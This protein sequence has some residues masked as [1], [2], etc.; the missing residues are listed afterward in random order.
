MNSGNWNSGDR[1]SGNF[2][3][4]NNLRFFFNKVTNILDKDIYYPRWLFNESIVWK[5][6]SE[7]SFEEKETYPYY[8]TTGGCLI[9][10]D[11]K[12]SIQESYNKATKE[13]QD[14]IEKLPNYDADV[15]FELFGID[16]RSL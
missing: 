4:T 7:M 5:Y 11:Y 13:E 1:N 12:I 6:E 10:N 2:N 16:R 9:V 14:S 3:T 8:K 15:L